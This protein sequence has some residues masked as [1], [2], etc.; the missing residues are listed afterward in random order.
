M[1][2]VLSGITV[3]EVGSGALSGL[4][5]MVMADFGAKVV[6]VPH[7][8]SSDRRAVWQRGKTCI[9]LDLDTQSQQL[10]ELIQQHA[11]VFI[12]DLS[13]RR[14]MELGVDADTLRAEC[15]DLI[16][17]RV[18]AF[19]DHNPYSHL[20][21]Q[22]QPD[23]SVVAAAI[24][25]MM[26]F[27]GVAPRTGPVYPVVKVGTHGASQAA[28][29]GILAQLVQREDLGLGGQLS[30]S[31][32]RA[33]TAYDLVGLGA[34]Q[35]DPSPIPPTDPLLVKPILNFQPVQCADGEWL[36]LGN[37][38]PHLQQNFLRAAGLTD[39]AQQLEE[40]SELPDEA[41]IEALRE[42]ICM[43]MQTR[44]RAEWIQLFE[45]DQG[46]AAHAYQST[47]Q[48]LVD[49]D[50]VANDHSVVVD[51]VRQL[52]VL[53]NFTGTPGAV[54]GPNQWATLAELDLPK[55]ERQTTLAEPCLPLSG[56]T[57]VESA[58]I[59]AS[60]FGASMLADLGARVIKLEPL[61]GDPFRV[62]AFGV[63][64]AR[65]NTDKESLAINLKSAEGQR[66]AQ[67]LVANADI[68]IHNYRPG[69]PQRLGLDYATL[70]ELNPALIHMSITGY[71]TKGPGAPRPST[72]PVPGAALGGV[73]QQFGELPKTLLDF[74]DLDEVARRLFRANEVNPDPNTSFVVA[75]AAT[76][77]LLAVR[78]LGKGQEI[79]LDMFGANAYANFD[80]FID[81]GNGSQRQ[82]L[83][84]DY[85]GLGDYQRLYPCQ[86]GWL[87]VYLPTAEDQS[88][89]HQH[90][91]SFAHLSEQSAEA[92]ESLLLPLGLCCVQAD[93]EVPGLRIQQSMFAQ[94]GVTARF[95]H[96]KHGS[97]LRH[98]AM[99][100]WPEVTRELRGPCEV[101]DA[102]EQL[103]AELGYTSQ[104]AAELAAS[105][106]V[107]V[108]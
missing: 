17:A 15:P 3:V 44:S 37:L 100:E 69:V 51:G 93:V 24:G 64:A 5:T 58:A 6:T 65:C 35:I 101:G 91:P 73:Q 82:P 26:V 7:G 36:Q 30:S 42:R 27:E 13:E 33:L 78:R 18:S 50:I 84:G 105:G 68:F 81:N 41:A 77:A 14:L 99:S 19:D 66:I 85:T 31:I 2:Q 23:E 39:I 83:N 79:F 108:G 67:Q 72:H 54:C 70:S 52:G 9:A 8:Q 102:T 28:L 1:S 56:V 29:A 55:V 46:V 10:T 49:P 74:A 47:Q 43:H 20:G 21:D 62:M 60:P 40:L 76:M 89:F 38:L 92:W 32:L 104:A 103:L 34:S 94:S 57:V 22:H 53:G 12:T 11:D 59:I 48:A 86:Q 4:P 61:D 80:D 63:G 90:V 95:T 97:G 45:A 25:R 106:V 107:R 16:H 98:G 87:Y 88:A 71:G 96:A 75:S